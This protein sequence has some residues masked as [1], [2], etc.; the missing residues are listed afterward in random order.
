MKLTCGDMEIN[1]T[2]TDIVGFAMCLDDRDWSLERIC[3]VVEA[4]CPGLFTDDELAKIANKVY[5]DIRS[6]GS[7][8]QNV[9]VEL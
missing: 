1:V 6:K 7:A 8:C 9:T 3:E 4:E 5:D 2:E